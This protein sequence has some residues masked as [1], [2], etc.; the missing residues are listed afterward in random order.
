M[1]ECDRLLDTE[2]ENEH[3]KGKQFIPATGNT[4]I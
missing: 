4:V 2:Y 1:C 3:V